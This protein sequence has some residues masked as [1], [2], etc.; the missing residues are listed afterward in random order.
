MVQKNISLIMSGDINSVSSS[1][2]YAFTLPEQCRVACCPMAPECSAHTNLNKGF[3]STEELRSSN[4]S[5]EFFCV[6]I[7][8]CVSHLSFL[9]TSVYLDK[10]LQEK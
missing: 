7:Y 3:K 8:F 2:N 5:L 6:G 1:E 4:I 9:T 10:K